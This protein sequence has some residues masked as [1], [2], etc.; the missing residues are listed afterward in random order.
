MIKTSKCL[1]TR[2]KIT[3]LIKFQN[4]NIAICTQFHGAK[5]F[6]LQKCNTIT[7]ITH[8][9]LNAETTS[10]SFS[11]N[12]EFIAF[13]SKSKIYILH[14][15]SNILIKILKINDELIELI[16]FDTES[17]YIIVA[18]KSG[19]LLQY[20]YDG[21]SFLA[22]L[23][24]LDKKN[25]S[26]TKANSLA[27]HKNIMA[28]G[29]NN[30][31]IISV[32]LHSR[33]NKVIL[34]N[35]IYKINSICFLNSLEIISGD[36]A[37]NIYINSLNNQQNI[38][39]I[40]TPFVSI[41]KILLMPNKEYIIVISDEKYVAIYES[42]YFKLVKNKYLE[43]NNIIID[44]IIVDD[45]TLLVALDNNS[46]EKVSLVNPQEIKKCLLNNLPQDAFNLVNQHPMLKVSQEYNVL[47]EVYNKIYHSALEALMQHNTKK[48][49]DLTKVF[50]YTDSK[51]KEL[52]ALFRAFENYP[53]FKNLYIEK[54]Y[55]LA[56]AISEKF[57]PLQKTFQYIKMEEIWYDAFKNAQ[58][59]IAF[60]KI[61]N[62]KALLN[63]FVTIRSKRAIVKLILNDHDNFLI[64]LKAIES[65]EFRK[66][67]EIAKKN[68]LFR[69][70]PTYKQVQTDILLSVD[71]IKQDL[72]RCNLKSAIKKIT[73]LHNVE[74]IATTINT[75]KDECKALKKLQDAYEEN[76]FI[77]CY[78]LLDQHN[79]LNSTD[80]GVLLQSHWLKI[81]SI[82]EE[83]A[84]K[85][86]IKEIKLTLGDLIILSTRSE[87]IGD[88]FRVGFQSKIKKYISKKLYEQS[89]LI[90]YSYIDIFGIDT[91][92]VHIMQN[93]EKLSN[94]NLAITQ[95]SNKRHNRDSWID[96]SIIK[97]L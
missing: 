79:I 83:H 47:E 10:L 90:I 66:V 44:M 85:G 96:S 32:N 42:R 67:Q 21:S 75:L 84:F 2:S 69:D 51:Q 55:P 6:S 46:I 5:V 28:C 9:D 74:S 71:E 30:G 24:S 17:K 62:A 97:E 89:E 86:S 12:G 3:K 58:R 52:D 65:K 7:N 33:A 80:L 54:K 22:R 14:I 57:P 29:D 13:A 53:R 4:D 76:N 81:I 18:T 39:K 73:K 59:Q 1:R 93:F 63:E 34:K 40:E 64:F 27:F 15:A 82:C 94:K 36:A 38:K 87:K 23:F 16:E 91:E 78:E 11:P 77:R 50:K 95:T 35:D 19:R 49:K 43:F 72:K 41:K 68:P 56:Y 37:G 48:A 70:I 8:K 25:I 20:R 61:D 45:Y 26:S 31:T 88:L 92:M 60:G